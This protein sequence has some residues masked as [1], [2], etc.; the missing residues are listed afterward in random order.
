[1]MHFLTL[2]NICEQF[3]GQHL[4]YAGETF[5]EPEL[6]YWVREKKVQSSR[7]VWIISFFSSWSP[8]II[9]IEVKAGKKQGHFKRSLQSFY[10]RKKKIFLLEFRFLMQNL[11]HSPKK[12]IF[13]FYR[14][15]K[16]G[17]FQ[18]FYPFLF[19]MVEDVYTTYQ[20]QI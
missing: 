3:V 13:F 8:K 4:L 7:R 15:T 12:L 16:G 11:P 18:T 5:E 1:M 19:Y 2:G 6:F 20:K 9:P 14:N 10:E 17:N